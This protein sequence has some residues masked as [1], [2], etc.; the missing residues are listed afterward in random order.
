VGVPEV[1]EGV[2]H[3][4]GSIAAHPDVRVAP[5]RFVQGP[6]VVAAEERDP[7]VNAHYV[8]VE[9]EDV[10][11]VEYLRR[12]RQRTEVEAVDPLREPLER[13]RHENVGQPV[14]D[15]VDLDPLACLSGQGLHKT[16]PDLVTL[17]DKRSDED[18]VLRGLDLVEHRLVEAD[19]VSVDL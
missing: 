5:S 2:V 14:E 1:D 10:P 11:R 9:P 19:P 13:G 15:D 4:P 8:A 16:A 17:P 3:L 12:P 18:L 7:A 6:D